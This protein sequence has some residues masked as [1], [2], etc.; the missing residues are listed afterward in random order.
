ML[1]RYC[2]LKKTKRDFKMLL[3]NWTNVPGKS[4]FRFVLYL[5]DVLKYFAILFVSLDLF[6]MTDFIFLDVFVFLHLL[7][8]CVKQITLVP[9]NNCFLSCGSIVT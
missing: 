1:F 7:W 4:I 2:L 8:F 5:A 3:L 6:F 9:I